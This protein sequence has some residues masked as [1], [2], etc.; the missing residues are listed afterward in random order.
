MTFKLS[1]L[2]ET[3]FD[4]VFQFIKS[5][6]GHINFP[7]TTG[8]FLPHP[9]M[10]NQSATPPPP[11][12]IDPF[13]KLHLTLNSDG[14]L[15]RN[16]DLY[17]TTAATPDSIS[18]PVLSKDIPI[19]PK[20]KTSAR[21]FLPRQALD[22]YPPPAAKLPLIIYFHGGGFITFS[23]DSLISHNFCASVAVEIQAVIVSVDYRLAPEFRL[24][25]AYDDAVEAILSIR[26]STEDWLV[27]FA[28]FSNCFL[29]GSSAGG[30]IAYF[31]GLRA[32][33]RTVD[34]LLPLRIRGLVL[35]EPFFGGVH[36][37]MSELRNLNDP[38]FPAAVA[39]MMWDLSLPAGADRDHEYCNPTVGGGSKDL[40]KV[41]SLGWRVLVIGYQGDPLI[42]RQRAVARFM[43]EK[44]VE[45]VGDFADG[46]CHG[47]VLFDV[48]VAKAMY[49]VL[50]DFISSYQP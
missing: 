15:T 30:N 9:K 18:T 31:A 4:D 25:A 40:E 38:I 50:K 8:H 19:N 2:K 14:S 41:G 10:T 21:I 13:K 22:N 28:D 32:A 37:T 3:K 33:A 17:G 46:G 48:A 44:G 20:N 42:D 36:R 23:A 39:D 24:P 35:D 43:V 26:S 45:V 16:S 5:P 47:A 12:I 29:M 27:K 11:P 49:E 34:E 7:I 1:K 6:A